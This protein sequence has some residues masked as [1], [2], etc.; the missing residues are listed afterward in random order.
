MAHVRF[1]AAALVM[2]GLVAAST[3]NRVVEQV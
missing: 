3:A 1:L 2:P